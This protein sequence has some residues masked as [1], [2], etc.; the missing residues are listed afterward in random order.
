MPKA[1]LF[2][3]NAAWSPYRYR[4]L[5]EFCKLTKKQRDFLLS[6]ALSILFHVM[7][8]CIKIVR[9]AAEMQF[10]SSGTSLL[11]QNQRAPRCRCRLGRRL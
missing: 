11:P 10:F 5:R 9:M 6:P 3:S 7:I 4:G 2:H 1:T 8:D